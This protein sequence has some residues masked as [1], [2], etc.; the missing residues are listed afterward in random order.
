MR[1]IALLPSQSSHSIR[2]TT[3]RRPRRSPNTQS[4]SGSSPTPSPTA[5]CTPPNHPPPYP[6][7]GQRTG[8][9]RHTR[10]Q[11]QPSAS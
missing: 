5:S 9:C 4:T 1:H 11:T 8:C 6:A 2:I 10:P 7:A 3:K